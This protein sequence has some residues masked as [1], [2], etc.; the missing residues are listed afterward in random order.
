M[1]DL[2]QQVLQDRLGLYARL[3]G[4]FP[5]PL[6]GTVYWSALG[7][8]G[9]TLPFHTWL[10][11]AFIGTGAIFPL[12]LGFA[13]IFRNPFMKESNAVGTVLV[14]AFIAMLLFWPMVLGAMQVAPELA[15]LILAIGMSAH[16]PVIG[17]SYGRTTLYTTHA[18]ARAIIALGI[19][20]YLPEARMTLLPFA[21]S[22]IYLVTVIAIYGDS[23]RMRKKLG[24]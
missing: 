17:W 23:A 22:A 21:V 5:I 14:P 8:L 3:R 10:F 9:Y 15:I 1:S 12:A 16:W 6:A 11:I 24:L 19:W 18:V 4:G 2:K 7:A 20:T 13:A